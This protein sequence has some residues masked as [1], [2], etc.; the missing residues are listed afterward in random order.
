VDWYLLPVLKR[1]SAEAH[2][3]G[4]SEHLG[5]SDLGKIR[6]VWMVRW[7]VPAYGHNMMPRAH[8][9]ML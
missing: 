1:R 8:A 6:Q 4:K 9:C 2:V 7:L 5:R 3:G